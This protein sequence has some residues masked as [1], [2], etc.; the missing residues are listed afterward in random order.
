[1]TNQH[2]LLAAML[3]AIGQMLTAQTANASTI[4][5]GI[6]AFGA[7]STLTTFNGQ[8]NGGEVNGT[9]V[10]G[11]LYQ[12]SLGNGNLIFNGGPGVTNN[13]SP[14]NI[15]SVGSAG[16]NTGILTLTMPSP[17]DTFGYGFAILTTATTLATFI[18]LFDGA[19]LVGSQSYFGAPDP[20]F[21]GGFAGIQ[22]TLLFNRVQLTFN[23]IEA[24]AFAVDN[25]RTFN[26][27]SVA[28]VPEPATLTLL[29]SGIAAAA[30]RR[31]RRRDGSPLAARG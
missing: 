10:D 3:L 15:V 8:T 4:A 21:T 14:L 17:V 16:A 12:Y 25:V 23:N 11:I 29:G 19:T 2:R 7:G 26:S 5:V 20:G 31:R 28:A 13:I 27:G 6:G 22:S 18:V 24:P 9:T 30:W 1:M